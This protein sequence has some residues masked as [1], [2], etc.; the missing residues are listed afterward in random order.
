MT[1]TAARHVLFQDL[2]WVPANHAQA[3]DRCYRLGQTR[4]VTVEYIRAA[5]SLDGYIAEL[6]ARK[7][8]LIAA[9]ESNDLPD[10]S[11]LQELQ[12]GL[13]ALAPALME[14]VRLGPQRR[15]SSRN[16]GSVG[17]ETPDATRQRNG[18]RT[19]RLLGVSEFS[20]RERNLSRH[21][22]VRW[23]S[24]LQPQGFRIPRQLQ[25]RAGGTS[26]SLASVRQ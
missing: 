18:D 13:R 22:R 12:N 25:T 21:V 26:Q 2:E 6:L 17:K 14:E 9:V 4:S 8:E 10:A 3:E 15:R 1:L 24:G 16:G 11:I 5:N 23:A 19:L 7:M 20:Q